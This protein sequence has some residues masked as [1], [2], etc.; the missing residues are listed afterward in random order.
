MALPTG[1]GKTFIAGV[2]MLN[3]AYLRF[4]PILIVTLKPFGGAVFHWFPDG[5]VI[6]LAPTKPLVAQ[7]I[8]ASHKSC[9]IPGS[10]AAELTGE[11][12]RAK[13]LN[14]VGDSFFSRERMFNRV[15]SIRASECST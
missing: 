8:D 6:F 12:S 9:G 7:Q 11:T 10:H 13:R 14:A 3:C 4:F 5:K 1:L 15:V 2:V